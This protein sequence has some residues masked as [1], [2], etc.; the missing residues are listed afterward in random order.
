MADYKFNC[1]QC[2]QHIAAPETMRGSAIECPSCHCKFDVPSANT[3]HTPKRDNTSWVPPLI[4]G[5]IFV[6]LI[7]YPWLRSDREHQ[8]HQL[9]TEITGAF[10]WTL[11][12]VGKTEFLSDFEI[13]NCPPFTHFA[14]EVTTNNLIGTIYASAGSKDFDFYCDIPELKKALIGKYGPPNKERTDGTMVSAD[15]TGGG[16]TIR[17]WAQ[18][19]SIS[20]MYVDDA[21]YQEINAESRRKASE[22]STARSN[23]FKKQF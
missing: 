4:A 19:N 7:S 18:T 17:F 3:I 13:S 9:K 8:V 15:W 23:N 10:G 1:P 2:Q 6:V 21:L 11:G 12:S 22:E 5:I 16:R 20:I 14:C